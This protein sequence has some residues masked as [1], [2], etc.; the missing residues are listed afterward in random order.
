M[1]TPATIIAIISLLP[2]CYQDFSNRSVHWFYFPLLTL[3]GIF[4]TMASLHSF[5]QML[6]N[7]AI[8]AAFLLL[9]IG[10]L[11]LYFVVVRRSTTPL[12]DN[13]IGW[14]DIL[15]LFAAGCFFSPGCFILFYVLSL[16]FSLVI[17]LALGL[18]RTKRYDSVPLAGLQALV[19]STLLCFE[20]IYRHTF[21]TDDWLLSKL[22]SQ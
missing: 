17:G 15:F 12:L 5:R 4:Y 7:T 9:Q 21:T 19:L 3:A 11:K 22:V 14:G 1:Q 6:Y 10:I 13:K 8:N 18:L 20:V 2:I 16:L